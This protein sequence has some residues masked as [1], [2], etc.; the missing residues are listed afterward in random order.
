MSLPPCW[1]KV[2]GPRRWS[3]VRRREFPIVE[4]GGRMGWVGG[5]GV[6]L[7]DQDARQEDS[8][9]DGVGRGGGLSGWCITG[10]GKAA[11]CVVCMHFVISHS[12][13]FGSVVGCLVPRAV[14]G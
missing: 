2:W 1:A 13:S 4:I 6:W 7:E 10:R 14:R 12:A 11:V 3:P 5:R 9:R 8:V